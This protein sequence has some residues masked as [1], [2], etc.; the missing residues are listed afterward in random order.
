MK[1]YVLIG[2]SYGI[3]ADVAKLLNSEGN[4]VV[5]YSRSIGNLSD[6]TNLIWYPY[7]ALLGAPDIE[8]VSE[9]IDGL[10]YLPGSIN[11]KPFHRTTTK[12]FLDDFQ[13]NFLGAVSAIQAFLPKLKQNHGSIV[14][15]STVAVSLGLPFHASISASKA[16]IE[17]LSKS[18]AAEL[19]PNIR[20]NVVAPSLTDT[21]LAEKL[22][23]SPEKKDA[24]SKRHPLNIYGKSIDIAE[25]IVFLLKSQFT[26]G[27]VLH[28]D[29][30]IST[31]KV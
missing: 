21:P 13:L 20:V 9:G 29:G 26:T 5:V 25:A 24:A 28:I 30:G 6:Y 31:L 3:G 18:L 23:S 14:L 11:L 15:M 27:Q 2:G 4:K 7:D 12:D 10:V 1:T 17:G 8:N 16:A 22:L 19:A